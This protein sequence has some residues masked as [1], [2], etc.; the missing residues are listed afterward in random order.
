MG[1]LGITLPGLLTQ[2]VSFLAIFLALYFLLYKR[3][4]RMLDAR[5]SRI[6]ESLEAA[7]RATP[8]G[9]FLGRAG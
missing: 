2:L 1:G 8:G 7:D 5:A 3:I 9:R 4:T 6:R